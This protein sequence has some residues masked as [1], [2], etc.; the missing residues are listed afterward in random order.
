MDSLQDSTVIFKCDS[1]EIVKIQ[2]TTEI[3]LISIHSI[4]IIEEGFIFLVKSLGMI[5]T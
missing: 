2:I 1:E 4:L 3:K 5:R